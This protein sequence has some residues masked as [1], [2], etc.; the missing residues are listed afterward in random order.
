M[1]QLDFNPMSVPT[2]P[3]PP[4]LSSRPQQ[5]PPPLIHAQANPP[6]VNFPNLHYFFPPPQIPFQ[7]P[8]YWPS[9]F[10]QYI[11]HHT[12]TQPSLPPLNLNP[13]KTP[14]SSQTK[15]SPSHG[16]GGN[17][18]FFALTQRP[19]S[20]LLTEDVWI[21]I[22]LQKN[23]ARTMVLSGLVDRAWTGSLHAW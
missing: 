4:H 13:P 23:R 15:P 7:Q 18:L 6:F 10:G 5:L 17:L 20:W 11:P 1:M 12:P 2:I 9:Q 16:N 8:C 19:S 14:P 21:L 22:P 3:P